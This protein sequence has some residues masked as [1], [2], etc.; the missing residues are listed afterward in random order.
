MAVGLSEAFIPIGV[1]WEGVGG[2]EMHPPI[3]SLPK[4]FFFASESKRLK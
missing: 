2:R 1:T 3:F 4:N